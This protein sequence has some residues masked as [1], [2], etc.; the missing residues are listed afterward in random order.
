MQDGDRSVPARKVALKT[1]GD[2]PTATRW[3]LPVAAVAWVA[4]LVF[5]AAMWL[6]RDPASPG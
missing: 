4:W 5:L 1:I 2:A 3:R 6:T